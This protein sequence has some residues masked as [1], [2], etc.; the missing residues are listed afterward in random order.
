MNPSNFAPIPIDIPFILNFSNIEFDK[1]VIF[2]VAVLLTIV[3][4]AEGQSFMATILGDT[5]SDGENNLY[6]NERFH[7][8]PIFHINLA[9]LI[10]F[11]VAGFGWSKQ[12]RLNT[13]N[14]KNPAL[15][16]MLVK[17]TGAFANLLLASIAGSIIFVMKNW[18]LE[19]QVF[20]IV[21]AVNVMVF[22]Y[23][24]IPIPP[25]A[26]AYVIVYI[27]SFFSPAILF[28][29]DAS[30]LQNRIIKLIPYF[31]VAAI[32]LSRFSGWSGWTLITNTLDPFV[33]AIFYFI[34]G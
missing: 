21:V 32:I 25:L 28:S 9:G 30:T 27:I 8:N 10:C 13:K 7:F 29:S 31:F 5:G 2:A 33:R 12:I 14:F 17:F 23:N 4:N 16:V 19:D 6:Q 1:V 20:S 22:V 26:G 3:V 11:A 15:A 24:L 18:N 34:A